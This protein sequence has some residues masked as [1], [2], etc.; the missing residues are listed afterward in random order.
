MRPRLFVLS[1]IVLIAAFA[2]FWL[3]HRP[4]P[5]SSQSAANA[6]SAPAAVAAAAANAAANASSQR[7]IQ[8]DINH[9]GL[10]PERAKLLFS[11]TVGP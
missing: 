8:L 1:V 2:V 6:S 4:K 9:L 10:T 5:A 11:L 7:A 3:V